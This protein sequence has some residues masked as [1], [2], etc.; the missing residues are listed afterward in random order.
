MIVNNCNSGEALS[1]KPIYI[2]IIEAR[3][4]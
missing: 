1:S 4:D 2:V 3:Q